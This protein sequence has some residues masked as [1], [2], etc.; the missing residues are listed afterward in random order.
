MLLMPD[1]FQYLMDSSQNLPSP[2]HTNAT[3]P[4]ASTSVQMANDRLPRA[5]RLPTQNPVASWPGCPLE[6]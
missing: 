2:I 5:I 4:G 1:S 3:S 6:R